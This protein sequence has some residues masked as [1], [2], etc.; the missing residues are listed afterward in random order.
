M[1]GK[2]LFGKGGPR[3]RKSAAGLA[4]EL[5]VVAAAFDSQNFESLDEEILLPHL[6]WYPQLV[7]QVEAANRTLYAVVANEAIPDLEADW[8]RLREQRLS[9]PF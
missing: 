1:F 9:W 6:A 7:R 5:V 8:D 4:I 3:F 2:N